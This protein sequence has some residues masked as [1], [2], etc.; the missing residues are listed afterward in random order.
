MKKKTALAWLLVLTLFCSIGVQAFAQ[1]S[2]ASYPD[3]GGH[4]AQHMIEEF[5]QRGYLNGYPD[6]TFGPNYPVTRAEAGAFVSRLGFPEVY[7]LVAYSEL[8]EG[9]WYYDEV[10][11]ATRTGFVHGYPD[12]TYRPD[13][14]IS[15]QEA[16]KL[17]SHFWG[18]VDME[19]FEMKFSDKSEIAS[20]AEP[21][22]R[23]LV[24]IGLLNGYPDN[25][26]R[27]L[28]N[29]TRAEFVKLFYLILVEP[30]YA[31][32]TLR[33]VD[34]DNLSNDIVEPKILSREIGN[35]VEFDAPEVPSVW[36]LVGDATQTHVIEQG[37]E[38][39]FAYRYSQPSGGG[40]GGG[41]ST[42]VTSYILSL[43]AS[44][45]EGGTVTGGGSY[46]AGT[47]V[48][49]SAAV[50]SEYQFAGWYEAVN[51]VSS[52]AQ[53][54]YTMP[55][56]NTTLV[57]SFIPEGTPLYT[58]SLTAAPPEGG[59]IIVGSGSYEEE[60]QIYVQADA[61]EGYEFAGWYEGVNLVNSNFQFIYTMPAQ[62]TTLEARFDEIPGEGDCV[63]PTLIYHSN[64][65]V[66]QILTITYE[67][68]GDEF[69]DW[70]NNADRIEIRQLLSGEGIGDPQLFTLETI[71]LPDDA[72][73]IDTP[74]VLTLDP[75]QIE[76]LQDAGENYIIVVITEEGCETE[77]TQ[78]VQAGAV[79]FLP[80][81]TVRKLMLLP[82]RELLDIMAIS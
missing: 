15:R 71:Y 41:G 61:S 68:E 20:W 16:T 51:L 6:G 35:T 52:D 27:P 22:L 57:A 31:N 80:T 47:A 28:A 36:Q 14:F 76:A 29:L 42:P 60:T 12:N 70:R 55:A 25:T 21:H 33:A 81:Q 3:I 66:D 49:V 48:T 30:A 53:F 77:V 44:P 78:Y 54:S 32:I 8:Q 7:P 39:V 75:A 58:L 74:G 62:N 50:Y 67:E 82:D 64:Y 43:T 23:K 5:T 65:D 59:T 56:Q 73:S 63:V 69:E 40:N 24:K 1:D 19:G 10:L 37:L 79:V 26:V 18:E 17:A 72:V 34:I 11:K 2:A 13:D 9:T 38:V 46:P 45:P 4:W